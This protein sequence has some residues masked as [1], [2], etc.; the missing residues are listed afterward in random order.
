MQKCYLDWHIFYYWVNLRYNSA[1]LKNFGKG[2]THIFQQTTDDFTHYIADKDNPLI[3]R[4]SQEEWLAMRKKS[5]QI[6][7]SEQFF[8]KSLFEPNKT[9]I[10]FSN[11]AIADFSEISMLDVVE[12]ERGAVVTQI[13]ETAVEQPFIIE[14]TNTSKLPTAEPTTLPIYDTPKKPKSQT[15]SKTE[16]RQFAKQQ[17]QQLAE[18]QAQQQAEEARLRQEKIE[19]A[20]AN[21]TI[22]ENL[23]NQR[24]SMVD[25]KEKAKDIFSELEQDLQ[26]PLLPESLSVSARHAYQQAISILQNPQTV[27]SEHA[28]KALHIVDKLA[29]S[30]IN[31][32]ML[33]LSLF[34][35]RGRAD[36]GIV[37]DEKRG[38][39]LL[40][41][42]ANLQDNRAE[43]LLS[44]LYFSGKIVNQ[45]TEK[46]K[47]WLA[48]SAEH[49]H[50]EA[51]KLQQGLI[52]AHTLQQNRVADDDY[53]KKLGLGVSVLLMIALLLIFGLKI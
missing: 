10:S 16:Q 29:K 12:E 46:A 14:Q 35:F 2:M 40:E 21:P 18:Q 41:Q 17:K 30:N 50:L 49:G 32:A 48:Q 19:K 38:L 25:N 6:G 9:V 52:T 3:D 37:K 36:L 23:Q 5:L 8:T 15:F 42:S 20:L 44:K 47:F 13:A 1:I 26:D 31:D 43:K 34:Y 4:F 27:N 7:K 28:I 51:Q 53:L 33:Y 22:H 39:A 24:K 45:D 11:Y